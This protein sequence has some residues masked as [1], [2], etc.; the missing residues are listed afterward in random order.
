[1][2][3]SSHPGTIM[4]FLRFAIA[5]CLT[6]FTIPAPA[7]DSAV[8]LPPGETLLVDVGIQQVGWQ[9]Y[10]GAAVAMPPGWDGHFEPRSGISYTDWGQIYGRRTLMMHSPWH[11]PPGKAW[12]D[13]PLA[14]PSS[15]PI[16]LS[17]GIAMGPDAATAAKSVGVT[18]SCYLTVDGRQQE[19][20]HLHYAKPEWK[21]Y[22]F[23]LSPHA[24]QAGRAAFP[25]RA[26]ATEKCLVRLLDV[27]RRQDHGRQR[28]RG[29]HRAGAAAD[30]LPRYRATEKLSL[31]ALSNRPQAGVVPSNLLPCTNACERSGDGFL[32]L[33]RADD[34]RVAYTYKPGSGT[35]DD[36]TVQVDGG[37]IFRPASG[38]GATVGLK[39]ADKTEEVG[40]PRR[41]ARESRRRQ[42]RARRALAIRDR[43]PAARSRLG[44][45]A[46]GQGGQGFRP[47]A[48]SPR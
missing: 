30:K 48:T 42:Q 33:Y 43:R 46:A 20:M 12:V 31:A 6:C 1:M 25:G 19:L 22:Q 24:G 34:C 23:D 40:A 17:F 39:H 32:F 16:R 11:V 47:L 5:L 4:P 3:P 15:G 9:S 35:L 2:P 7:A 18:F 38:G 45:Q 44:L 13:Y 41:P 28:D 27:R 8:T 37:P 21:D 36:F 26:G 14:L 10:G 29:P